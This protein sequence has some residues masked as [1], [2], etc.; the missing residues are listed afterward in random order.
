MITDTGRASPSTENRS[1]RFPRT[2][3]S[4]SLSGETVG[5]GGRASGTALR[6]SLPEEVGRIVGVR[7]WLIV[8][9]VASLICAVVVA[10]GTLLPPHANNNFDSMMDENIEKSTLVVFSY[11]AL[12]VCAGC[13]LWMAILLKKLIKAYWYLLTTVALS[14]FTIVVMLIYFNN[15]VSDSLLKYQQLAVDLLAY[16]DMN[17][18][19][20]Y[21]VL[22]VISM[23][24]W[25]DRIKLP[26]LAFNLIAFGAALELSQE[27]IPGRSFQLADLVS[28]S[29]GV[30]VG[31]VGVGLVGALRR[32]RTHALPIA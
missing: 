2:R 14:L 18:A 3:A 24:G 30:F 28:N 21:A 15:I 9:R 7:G 6:R 12:F 32:H 13:F 26:V 1:S 31:L 16:L 11:I 27:Y 20:A 19:A 5:P 4:V 23:I 22:S 25:R 29:L 8:P 10:I 17:H